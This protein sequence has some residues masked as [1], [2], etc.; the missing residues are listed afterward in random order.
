MKMTELRCSPVTL[1]LLRRCLCIYSF[2]PAEN[3][4]R[5]GGLILESVFHLLLF[6]HFQLLLRLIVCFS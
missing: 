4:S 6:I 1:S 5:Q 2:S 3:G